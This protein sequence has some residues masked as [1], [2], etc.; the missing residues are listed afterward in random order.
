MTS[1]HFGGWAL[2]LGAVSKLWLL[3]PCEGLGNSGLPRAVLRGWEV[4]VKSRGTA[5]ADSCPSSGSATPP[6]CC[7]LSMFKRGM[8]AVSSPT[9]PKVLRGHGVFTGGHSAVVSEAEAISMQGT[10]IFDLGRV[11]PGLCVEAVSLVPWKCS[12]P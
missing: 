2:G 4:R 8:S 6:V 12:K 10:S 5:T 7:A 11:L 3:G 1:W 9:L